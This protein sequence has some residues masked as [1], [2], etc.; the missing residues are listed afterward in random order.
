MSFASKRDQAL[1]ILAKTGLR[2]S[3]YEPPL[4]RLFWYLGI[5]VPPPHFAPMGWT[6]LVLGATFGPSWGLMMWFFF[7]RDQGLSA[8]SA[9]GASI[10]AGGAFG[11]SMSVYYAWGKRK[12]NLPSWKSLTC[13]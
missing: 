8:L 9:T 5:P 12:Y 11:V 10:L 1:V 6:A 3:N 13:S 2:R 7:W 4:L